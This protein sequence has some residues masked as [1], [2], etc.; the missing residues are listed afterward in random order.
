M[1]SIEFDADE[2]YSALVESG[3]NEEKAAALTKAFAKI[4]KAKL[5]ELTTKNDLSETRVDIVK[6]VAAIVISTAVVQIF[7]IIGVLKLLGKI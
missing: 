1:T 4:E 3:V 5:E 7:A 6:W 2:F